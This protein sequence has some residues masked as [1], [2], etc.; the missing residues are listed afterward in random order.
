[1]QNARL[2]E[3]E[4]LLAKTTVQTSP[5]KSLVS[6]S[7]EEIS[8]LREENRVVSASGACTIFCQLS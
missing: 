7:T 2:T 3:L 6:V 5:R 8:G 4:R 1:M